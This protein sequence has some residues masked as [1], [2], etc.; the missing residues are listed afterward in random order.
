[1]HV[2]SINGRVSYNGSIRNLL[3]NVVY[4]VTYVKDRLVV[5]IREF[6]RTISNN[7]SQCL[8]II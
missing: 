2:L 4:A 5:H 6:K 7:E 8:G 1:M 3:D